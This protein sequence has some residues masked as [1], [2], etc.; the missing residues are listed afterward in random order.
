MDHSPIFSEQVRLLVDVLPSVAKQNCFAL[1]G[2]TALNLFVRDLPRLSVDIDL[3][4]LPLADRETSLTGIDVALENIAADI[5]RTLPG[6]QVSAS[7]VHG[8]DQRIKL[9]VVRNSVAVKI[10]V[11]PVLRGC[12]YESEW[13]EIAP[14][15]QAEFGYV[16]MQLLSFEDLYAGKLCAALDRQHPR[17]LFDVRLLLSN[18]GISARLKDAFIVYLLGHNRPMAELLTPNRKDIEAIYH[19]EFVGMTLDEVSYESLLETREAMIANIH[20]LLTDQ[21][22]QFLLAVKRGDAD[23]REFSLPDVEWLPAIQWK[24]HNLSLMQA[25]RRRSALEALERALYGSTDTG[26]DDV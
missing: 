23:W 14:Q 4:Y 19:A 1:K 16:R 22:K 8:T 3:A 12:V 25:D 6:A 5:M 21:D 7:F 9:L 20:R 24:L 17:D 26:R 13:R 15:A 18:E 11:T 10:E 2:G